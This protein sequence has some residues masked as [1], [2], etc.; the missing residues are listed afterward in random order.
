VAREL[1]Q[2]RTSALAI[3]GT[4]GTIVESDTAAL[5]GH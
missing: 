4:S 1:N 5:T 3:T 2:L